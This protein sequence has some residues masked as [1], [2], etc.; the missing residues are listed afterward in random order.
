MPELEALIERLTNDATLRQRG[1]EATRQAA[2]NPV[3]RAL[4]WD[5]GNLDEV[6]P[7]YS[8]RSGGRVDYCLRYG[9]RDLVLIE[10]KRAGS[11]LE[12]HQRQL[13]QYA[14]GVG[15]ELA[16]LTN[17]LD[18]W[19]YLPVVPGRSWEQRRFA[20]IDF[21]EQPAADAASALRRFIGHD[22]SVRGTAP[23]E[24]RSEFDRQERDRRVRASL[25]EAWGR[26]L[27]DPRVHDLLVME[28][29]ELSG[30]PPEAETIA[31]FLRGISGGVSV[32]ATPTAPL[33]PPISEPAEATTSGQKAAV[34][35]QKRMEDL[36]GPEKHDWEYVRAGHA[37][38]GVQS[39]SGAQLK[40]YH[41]L[42]DRRT[43]N[44][45]LVGR[46]E[47]IKYAGVEPPLSEPEA[48]GKS[49][50]R[51][52]TPSVPPAAFLLD[53]ARYEV[54]SWRQML[55]RL[56]EELVRKEGPSFTERVLPLKGRKR[57]YF[58]RQPDDLFE[59][60]RIA[61]SDLYV[62]GNLSALRAERIA[63]LTLIAVRGTDDGFDIELAE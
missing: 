28:V 26:V 17:G 54:T 14:F 47:M 39:V 40:A 56:S 46:G 31:G 1:E 7:E 49:G 43:G 36:L 6:D 33:Q 55:V 34:T 42:R 8:D 38:D 48:P 53:G 13:L 29:E 5:T 59:P 20:R 21:R 32:V 58:S 19:L 9:G 12:E 50:R 18:W 22:A 51:S 2:V 27:R 63:R 10:V 61:G 11:E 24:A 35:R 37:P 44:E 57:A 16:V 25:P 60:L 4:G 62:E 3:L 30:H 45:V 23:A 41:V 15:A 52:K